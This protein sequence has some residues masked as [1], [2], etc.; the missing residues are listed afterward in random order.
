MVVSMPLGSRCSN[1]GLWDVLWM[2]S[3]AIRSGKDG[4]EVQF[5][6]HVP[7]KGQLAACAVMDGTSN[8]PLA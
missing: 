5:A 4:Q 2:L 3:C 6:V 7:D 8:C 1:F